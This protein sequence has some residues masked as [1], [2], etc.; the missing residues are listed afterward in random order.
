MGAH[1]SQR[2]ND[3]WGYFSGAKETFQHTARDTHS[4]YGTTPALAHAVHT[5]LSN[6]SL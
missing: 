6:I 1:T 3:H 2:I 4:V 5:V